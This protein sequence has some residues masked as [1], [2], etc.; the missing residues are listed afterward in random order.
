MYADRITDSMKAAL[1]ETNR[2]RAIQLE[3]NEKHNIKPASIVKQ[4]R[5]LTDRLKAAAGGDDHAPKKG[6]IRKDAAPEDMSKAELDKL[7][8]EIEKLMKQAAKDLEFEKAA[9]LRDQMMEL[10]KVLVLKGDKND[11]L[12]VAAAAD[13]FEE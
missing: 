3:Y 5:D 11:P 4:V 6:Q 1:D 7:T 12:A 9:A 13:A 8:R 10:R 2:R